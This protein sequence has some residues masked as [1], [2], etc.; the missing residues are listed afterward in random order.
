M[1]PTRL[2]EDQLDDFEHALLRSARVDEPDV[3]AVARAAL[4]LGVGTTTLTVA[5]ASAAASTLPVGSTAVGTASKVGA[6]GI[7]K[8]LGIGIAG[9]LMTTGSIELARIYSAP[10]QHEAAAPVAPATGLLRAR[11]LSDRSPTPMAPL[12]A[13]TIELVSPPGESSAAQRAIPYPVARSASGGPSARASAAATVRVA[14]PPATAPAT[15][16]TLPGAAGESEGSRAP[17]I[18]EEIAN[19]ERARR[20]LAAGDAGKALQELDAYERN[21]RVRALGTEA[22]VLR[23]EALLQAGR[24]ESAVALARR[25]LAAQPN[26]PHAARL[27][28]IT[29]SSP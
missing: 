6:L 25:L 28:S 21:A 11:P 2:L 20:A 22:A 19:L 10:H 26:G 16:S 15:T 12:A 5:A 14:A 23:V 1:D 18:A 7:V 9:G 3:Q 24:R 29:A 27:R 4:A 8:W 13:P 17:S